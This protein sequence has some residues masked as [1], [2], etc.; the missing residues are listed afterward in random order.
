MDTFIHYGMA[1]SIQAVQDAGLPTGDALTEEQA[2]RIGVHG[3]LGHRRPADDR[4]THGDYREARPA[5]HLAVLRAG[6]DHQH[7]L[8]PRV[9]PLRLPGPNLAVVTACTT[10]LHCIG[11]AGRHDRVRRCR[12]DGR[13]RRR[14]HRVAAGHRRLC[15]GARAV[16]AQRRSAKTASRPWDRTATASCWARA[17]ACWCSRSTSTRSAAA[18]D[19]RRAGRLRHERRRV[20][21]DGAERR[22]PEAQHGRRCAMPASTPTRCST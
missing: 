18:Q 8:G 1:A 13:R 15:G 9:D 6:L 10:G 22:R 17:P 14:V 21:H 2:E 4:E 20:P 16:H 19:L 5:P 3:R 7:D 12:R 11:E